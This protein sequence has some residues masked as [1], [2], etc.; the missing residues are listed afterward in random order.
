[1]KTYVLVASADSTA[2]S[3]IM[4]HLTGKRFRNIPAMRE[5]VEQVLGLFGE[6]EWEFYPAAQFCAQWNEYFCADW[7]TYAFGDDVPTPYDS[8]IA[9]LE[10]E[11]DE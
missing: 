9:F 11:H 6:S 1:M 2:D 7:R 8:Y 3:K 5:A 4:A 10:V